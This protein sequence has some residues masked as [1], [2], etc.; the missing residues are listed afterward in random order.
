MKAICLPSVPMLQ[1]VVQ[2]ILKCGYNLQKASGHHNFF[3]KGLY[4]SNWNEWR[5]RKF[6]GRYIIVQKIVIQK[7][8]GI[9]DSDNMYM[10]SAEQIQNSYRKKDIVRY[11]CL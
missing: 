7:R 5:T 3:H 2:P 6:E 8:T 4:S 9:N 11:C 1:Q 10:E